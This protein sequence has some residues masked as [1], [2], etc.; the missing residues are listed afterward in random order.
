MELPSTEG[1]SSW[2]ATRENIS[3]G[4]YKMTEFNEDDMEHGKPA[5]KNSPNNTAK[6]DKL[7]SKQRDLSYIQRNEAK[8]CD[9]YDSDGE[10]GPFITDIIMVERVEEEEDIVLTLEGPRV[11][12]TVMFP[13]TT[14]DTTKTTPIDDDYLECV[15]VNIEVADMIR[16]KNSTLKN[17]FLSSE[18]KEF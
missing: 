10:S 12:V 5:A 4:M 9:R 17:E 14:T 11:A 15:F 3:D 1:P 13:D 2:E 7:S 16:M 8:F 6:T 18:I